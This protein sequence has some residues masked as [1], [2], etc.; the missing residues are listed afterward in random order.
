MFEGGGLGCVLSVG[1]PAVCLCW[2]VCLVTVR[3]S[4]FV[5]VL[6][7]ISFVGVLEFRSFRSSFVQKFVRSFRS[8]FA[9]KFVRSE[10][11]SFRSSFVQNFVRSEGR[12]EVL[13][14]FLPSFQP[15]FLPSFLPPF[16]RLL[17]RSFVPA[18]SPHHSGKSSE[19][20]HTV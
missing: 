11:R 10:L 14:K 9:Q 18:F 8:S 15:S 12:P 7:D 2:F 1:R 16:V 13:L 4:S 3:R 17:V 6:V 19:S 5:G 20:P